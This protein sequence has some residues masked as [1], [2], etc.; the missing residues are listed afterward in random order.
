M[1]DGFFEITVVIVLAA[2]LGI[3]AKFLK[4]PTIVAYL[5]AGVVIAAFGAIGEGSQHTLDIMATF[6]I[7]LL[8]FLI[9]LEMR[10]DTMK[11]IG[12]AALLTGVGQIVVTA[13][14]GF[15]ITQLL[16]FAIIPSLY[17]A[18]ALTFSSTIVV[19]KLLLEKRE[20][21]TLYGRIVVGFLIV[22]DVVAIF[23]LIF[24][25]G[26]KS[27]GGSVEILTLVGTVV[28]SLLLFGCTYYLSKKVLYIKKFYI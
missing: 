12:K 20:L 23:I 6:G 26:L 1:T 4:Q 22:Q 17:I 10:F 16:G 21:Q 11:T 15:G 25:S 9:G 3:L 18:F 14:L 24:L 7:T 27:T 5:I 28:K 2:A 19:V 8:L 13:L